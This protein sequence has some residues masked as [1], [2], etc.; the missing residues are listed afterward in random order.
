[1]TGP[2]SDE[3]RAFLRRVLADGPKRMAAVLAAAEAA[4]IARGTLLV[5][6][7]DVGVVSRK[8]PDGWE[9]LLAAP[10]TAGAGQ[11]SLPAEREAPAG[12]VDANSATPGGTADLVALV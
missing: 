2:R 9:W 6:K 8:Q 3:A 10:A 7:A 5:I 11:E 4:G 1:M 12:S